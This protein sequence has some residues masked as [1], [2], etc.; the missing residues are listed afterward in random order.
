M[1]KNLSQVFMYGSNLDRERLLN[2]VLSW[3]GQFQKAYLTGYELRFNKRL[4]RG[5]VAANIILHPT[6]RVWGITIELSNDDLKKMDRY[7]GHP[8]H[9]ERQ[10]LKLFLEN[11]RETSAYVYIAQPEHILEGKKP[12][13]N[14]FQYVI[15]GAIN[16]GLPLEYV[17]AIEK[18][19]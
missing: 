1:K 18:L 16:C 14:Y 5:G 8:Y 19:G 11:G 13:L 3:N 9:Y 12:S 15:N 7:E 10:Q 2:R 17:R 6:R 4:R